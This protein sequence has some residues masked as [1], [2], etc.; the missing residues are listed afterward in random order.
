MIVEING[1]PFNPSYIET[2]ENLDSSF[3]DYEVSGQSAKNPIDTYMGGPRRD[4]DTILPGDEIKVYIKFND[5]LCKHVMHCYNVVHEDH[6][7]MI[8]W[9]IMEPGKG[10]Q[11]SKMASEVY[12]EPDI[13][14]HLEARPA[15]ATYQAGDGK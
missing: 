14:P 12:G 6:A 3:I 8:R 2:I 15:Q 1:V 11:E 10:F 5:F 13:P 4:V 7:M 9:D